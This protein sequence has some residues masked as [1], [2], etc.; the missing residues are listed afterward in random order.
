[1]YVTVVIPSA[2]H[3]SDKRHSNIPGVKSHISCWEGIVPLVI[4]VRFQAVA[5]AGNQ[6]R[7][8]S[9]TPYAATRL[10]V[11]LPPSMLNVG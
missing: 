9:R 3:D 2:S 6:R 4:K 5:V 10:L 7:G 11:A 8:K 1:M